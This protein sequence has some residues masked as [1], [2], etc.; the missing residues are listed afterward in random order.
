ML[1]DDFRQE[2]VVGLILS[3]NLQGSGCDQM[4]PAVH[5]V[6]KKGSVTVDLLNCRS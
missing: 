4:K 2:N 1:Y 6:Y 5:N 3:T